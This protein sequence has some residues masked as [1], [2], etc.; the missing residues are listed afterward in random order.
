MS[1][2]Q[3]C[4]PTR[5]VDMQIRAEHVINALAADA[6][7]EQF[8]PP[9]LLAGKIEWRRMPFTFPRARID[10]ERVVRRAN[11]KGLIRDEHHPGCWVEHLRLHH[12]QVPLEG[13][14]I[15]GRK[16]ILW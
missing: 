5:V 4:I 15:V 8:I 13:G 2:A 10:Q 9:P 16:E 14:L 6:Q 1:A 7:S 11:D 3:R 12:L